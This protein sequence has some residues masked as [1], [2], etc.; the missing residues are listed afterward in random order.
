MERGQLKVNHASSWFNFQH[1]TICSGKN[2]MTC[3]STQLLEIPTPKMASHVVS[4][5][6]KVADIGLSIRTR[7]K[8]VKQNDKNSRSVY[9]LLEDL[10]PVLYRF[11][12]EEKVHVFVERLEEIDKELGELLGRFD[13]PSVQ[14]KLNQ[15]LK[16]QETARKFEAIH[17]KLTTCILSI[18]LCQE[19]ERNRNVEKLSQ[20]CSKA[21]DQLK[22][23]IQTKN[24][25]KQQEKVDQMCEGLQ[26]DTH[27]KS[28]YCKEYSATLDH[29]HHVV[30]VPNTSVRLEV[31]E[32]AL[33][34]TETV[35]ITIS[36]YLDGN[37]HLPLENNQ[38]VLGPTVC[39]EPHSAKF[40]KPVVLVLPHS[41]Q[42]ITERNI[43][44]WSKITKAS[45]WHVIFDGAAESDASEPATVCVAE[46]KVKIGVTHFSWFTVVLSYLTTGGLH[47]LLMKMEMRP[48]MQVIGTDKIHVRVYAL[49][50]YQSQDVRYEEEKVNGVQCGVM[51]P[52]VLR[53]NGE[54]ISCQI[55]AIMQESKWKLIAD[56]KEILYEPL[57]HGLYAS[58]T[59]TFVAV[60][61]AVYGLIRAHQEDHILIKESTFV[62][63]L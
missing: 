17:R 32:G 42:N 45:K 36:V 61:E 43:T 9:Q 16:Q 24:Y 21:V 47:P 26:G 59:F 23:D 10:E 51:T 41:A 14:Q 60:N 37:H 25:S 34:V 49:R 31:P 7:L 15:F 6:A 19:P 2:E 3:Q 18:L 55:N 28:V 48:Y 38:F 13:D 33:C 56:Q 27:S 54:N 1:V 29:K 58:C 44:V 39:I 57:Q 30:K 8:I 11:T 52:F 35:E 22:N 63:H 46:S 5:I 50:E 62:C 53:L 40:L 4:E 12:D 20:D